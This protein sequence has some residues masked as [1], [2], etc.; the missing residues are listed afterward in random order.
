MTDAQKL[1]QAL[2]EE[3]GDGLSF[4]LVVAAVRQR[5]NDE[6][7][8]REVVRE[9]SDRSSARR[10]FRSDVERNWSKERYD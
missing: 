4:P 5:S 2:L 8:L 6:A 9:Y 1:V 7:F 3:H 10:T